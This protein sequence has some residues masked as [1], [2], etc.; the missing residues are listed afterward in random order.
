MRGPRELSCPGDH[1]ARG[2]TIF[3]LRQNVG[4]T[5]WPGR[6][7]IEYSCP[8][9]RQNRASER[10]RFVDKG[11]RVDA[12][13]TSR[14]PSRPTR[15]DAVAHASDDWDSRGDDAP[16]SAVIPQSFCTTNPRRLYVVALVW[17][18]DRKTPV[19][20]TRLGRDMMLRAASAP[21]YMNRRAIVQAGDEVILKRRRECV[22]GDRRLNVVHPTTTRATASR[23]RRNRRCAARS[24][25]NGARGVRVRLRQ[26]LAK[27]GTAFVGHP[28][29]TPA[30]VDAIT[31]AVQIAAPRIDS[32]CSRARGGSTTLYGERAG[33]DAQSS[34]LRLSL[35][36]APRGE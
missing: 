24:I 10:L 11:R 2:V 9:G 34:C 3:L 23:L 1:L 35:V 4:H 13:W 16:A 20:T 6:V 22:A 29:A 15:G 36:E 19:Q 12:G 32:R 7:L 17:G 28:L 31:E 26:R 33:R 8:H 21:P 14:T 27:E 25:S 30:R 18:P 5:A